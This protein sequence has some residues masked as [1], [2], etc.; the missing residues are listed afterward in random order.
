ML[1]TGPLQ[2]TM[3]EAPGATVTVRPLLPGP[4][5]FTLQFSSSTPSPQVFLLTLSSGQIPLSL[6]GA[7]V[8][9]EIAGIFLT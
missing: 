7:R 6:L 1:V 3:N 2:V 4:P 5:S 9:A 8:S